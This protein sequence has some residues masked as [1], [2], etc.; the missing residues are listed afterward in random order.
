MPAIPGHVTATVKPT[1][2]VACSSLNSSP[3]TASEVE[4]SPIYILSPA[5]D[6][7]NKRGECINEL[8][9]RINKDTNASFRN[10]GSVVIRAI[11]LKML[12]YLWIL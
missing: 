3:V 12:S 4:N 2:S 8:Y 7:D 11:D 6:E 5:K 10:L 9:R 1:P